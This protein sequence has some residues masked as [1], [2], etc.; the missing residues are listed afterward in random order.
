[1]GKMSK[2][3]HEKSLK[4]KKRQPLFVIT[5]FQLSIHFFFPKIQSWGGGN[6]ILNFKS[7]NSGASKPR[8]AVVAVILEHAVRPSHQLGA[9]S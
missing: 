4:K 2:N 7:F 8:P 1:M 9:V 6:K 5:F 3:D